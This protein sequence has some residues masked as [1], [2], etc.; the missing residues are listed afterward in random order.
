MTFSMVYYGGKSRLSEKI[1]SLMPRHTLY[2]EPF[3]GGASVFFNKPRPSVSNNFYHEVINDHDKRLVN[4]Y[5]QLRD[6]G[7]A[8]VES[9]LLTPYAEEEHRLSKDLSGEG[10]EAARRYFINSQQSFSGVLNTG[11]RRSIYSVNHGFQWFHRV[12]KMVDILDRMAGV[13]ITCDKAITVIKQFDSP[14][15][16]FYL[17]PPYPGA[18]Q[19]HYGGYTIQDFKDLVET[20]NNCQ[21]SFLLSNYDQPEITIPSDWERFEFDV[22]S[23]A[24]RN[25][26]DEEEGSRRRVEVLWRRFNREPVRHEI[27]KLYD[28]GKFD[29]FVSKDG[30]S[31]CYE[32]GWQ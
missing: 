19:G 18:D 4:F 17:D 8:L 29:C 23:T 11:W 27:Q 6:N 20:L 12:E 16:F 7:Q 14:H 15:T 31:S 3:C 2:V 26:D 24:A 10:L 1:I 13:T 28:L 30:Y 22:Y 21:G 5:K 25:Q 9:L 32:E